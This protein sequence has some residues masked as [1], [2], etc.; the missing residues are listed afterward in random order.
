MISS[1]VAWFLVMMIMTEHSKKGT[2]IVPSR[3][4]WASRKF[5]L[6]HLLVLIIRLQSSFD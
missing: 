1:Q 4:V 6:I 5:S 3:E 2:W